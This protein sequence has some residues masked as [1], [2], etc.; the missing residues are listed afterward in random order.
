LVPGVGVSTFGVATFGFS[1]LGR[2][3]EPSAF[4]APGRG[5]A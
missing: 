5:V 1:S 3:S 4:S 2:A